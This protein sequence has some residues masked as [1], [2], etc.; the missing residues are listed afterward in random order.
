M[1]RK[2]GFKTFDDMHGMEVERI[3]DMLSSI[4]YASVEWDMHFFDPRETTAA[5]RKKLRETAEKCG[6]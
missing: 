1:L 5:Q 4:G 6:L 2:I 3:C